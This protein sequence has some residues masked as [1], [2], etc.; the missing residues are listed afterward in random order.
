M[1]LN[2]SFAQTTN[3]PRFR[4]LWNGKICLISDRSLMHPF[5]PVFWSDAMSCLE[6]QYDKIQSPHSNQVPMVSAMREH[7]HLSKPRLFCFLGRNYVI[8]TFFG[9]GEE[10]IR[11]YELNFWVIH[12]Q[13]LNMKRSVE[14][15]QTIMTTYL[16]SSNKAWIQPN[17]EAR[18]TFFLPHFACIITLRCVLM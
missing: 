1:L 9:G 3:I 13:F 4:A 7:F 11:D 2:S 5:A 16:T 14:T 15:D 8:G 10:A 6:K 17:D 12:T 18:C